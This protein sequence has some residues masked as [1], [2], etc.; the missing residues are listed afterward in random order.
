M[1]LTIIPVRQ[2]RCHFDHGHFLVSFERNAFGRYW[3]K[4]F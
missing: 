2:W 4:V 3:R 1:M